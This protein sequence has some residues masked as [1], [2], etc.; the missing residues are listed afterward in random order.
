MFNESNPPSELNSKGVQ[1]SITIP[2]RDK[3][4]HSRG[5]L[6]GRNCQE[7]TIGPSMNADNFTSYSIRGINLCHIRIDTELITAI[8]N[9]FIEANMKAVYHCV[10]SSHSK[11]RGDPNFHKRSMQR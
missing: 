6:S 1:R 9:W 8:Y 11:V 3:K 4:Q 10:L 5:G 7:D 2:E